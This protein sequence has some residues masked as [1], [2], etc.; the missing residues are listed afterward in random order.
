MKIS[1]IL[2]VIN[3]IFSLEQTVEIILQEN[4]G[5]DF[6]FIIVTSPQKTISA[7]RAVIAQLQTKFLSRVFHFEQ[8]LPYVGGAI[9]DA[10][11][12][13]EG[14]YSVLMAPDLET[15]PHSVKDLIREIQGG[16][17][18]VCASRWL[19]GGKF[20]GYSPLKFF[21]NRIFQLFFKFLYHTQLDD[22]TFAY[23][24]Y[25]TEILKKIKWEE[26]RHPF[27]LETIIKPLRLGCRVAQVPSAW[28]MREEGESQNT[29]W[30]NF[31]YFRIGL[32]TLFYSK[33]DILK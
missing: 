31:E 27:F 13:C 20:V 25:K 15:D 22:L 3:E 4:P 1:I 21:L 6:K 23:R 5:V 11:Q 8:T 19:K 16:Y 2:P 33:R 24:I 32:K 17:D 14:Q 9:R 12:Y 30:R 7:S 29:F 10:F 26:L 18:I 28:R